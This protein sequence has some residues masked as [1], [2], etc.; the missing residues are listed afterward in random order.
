MIPVFLDTN[1]IL[2]LCLNREPFAADAIKVFKAIEERK[3][4][5][6]VSA[7][8][9]TDIYYLAQRQNENEVVREFISGLVDIVKIVAIDR[10]LISKALNTSW[11]DFEDAIQYSAAKKAGVAFIVTRNKKDFVKSDIA[12]LLPSELI[13]LIFE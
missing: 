4:L 12:V 6:F 5:P 13:Q 2:D 9:I 1:V 10:R 11:P 7:T 3:I 8:T